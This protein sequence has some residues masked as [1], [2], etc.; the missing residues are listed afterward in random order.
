MAAGM[1]DEPPIELKLVQDAMLLD[2]EIV[3]TRLEPT[4]GNE[5]WHVRIRI[6]AE[7]DLIETCAL[8]L[9]FTLGMLS[10]HDARPRGV[11]DKWF[12]TND[13]WTVSDMLRHLEFTHGRLHFHADYVRGRGVKTTIE[14]SSD[15]QVLVETVNRGQAA[16]RWLDRLRGKRLLEALPTGR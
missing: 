13:E 16:T 2:L 9:I 10:F 7:E 8:G 5:N 14:V 1:N 12:E 11:S 4:A 15:G 3:D 6:R